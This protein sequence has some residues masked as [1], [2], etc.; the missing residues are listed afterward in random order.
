MPADLRSCRVCAEGEPRPFAKIDGRRY[1]RCPSCLATLEEPPLPTREQ[2]RAVYANHENDPDDPRYRAFLARLADPLLARLPPESEVLD[3]GCG[4]GPALAAM[5][6]EAGHRVALYDPFFFSETAPLS[7]T[8]DAVTCTEAAEHFHDPAAAFSLMMACVRPGG[9]L[10]IMT[11]FQT[12]DA[13]F[14]NWHYRR[15]PTHVVFYRAETLARLAERAG[16]SIDIPCKNV[17][18]MQRPPR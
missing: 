7:Q 17:A 9:L 6:R 10:A 11:C 5:L 18:I 12:D 4:P 1:V 13:A 14:A 16:W 15:D 8:F 3:Y 2:E